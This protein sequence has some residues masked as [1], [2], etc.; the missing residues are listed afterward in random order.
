MSG[1]VKAIS[2]TINSIFG[3]AKVP[4]IKAPKPI[5]QA[6]P[7]SAAAKTE[8]IRKARARAQQGREGTIYS[9]SYSNANLAGTA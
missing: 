1:A 4:D 5:I 8:A 9:R 7:N 2:S 3:S 6:D